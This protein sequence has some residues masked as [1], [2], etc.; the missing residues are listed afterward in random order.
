MVHIKKNPFLKKRIWLQWK[1]VD[2]GETDLFIIQQAF[3]EHIL[4]AV[5]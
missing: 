1:L 5:V 4:L 3:I 2:I